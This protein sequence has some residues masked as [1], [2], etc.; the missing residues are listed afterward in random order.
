MIHYIVHTVIWVGHENY[1]I[2]SRGFS[3]LALVLDGGAQLYVDGRHLHFTTGDIVFF[4]KGGH[5]RVEPDNGYV[6]CN[7]INFQCDDEIPICVLNGC[8]DLINQFSKIHTLWHRK[9][10]NA[11]SE[12][13]C[14]G[15]LYH[16]FAEFYRRR[17]I[18]GIPLRKKK[19]ISPAL[20]Y[21]RDY[22]TDHEITINRLAELCGM[23]ER[24]FRR[25][26]H[27]VYGISP[28]RYLTSLRVNYAKGLLDGAHTVSQVALLCGFHDIY[29]FSS[30]FKDE[31]GMSPSEYIRT[32]ANESFL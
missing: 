13:D 14:M 30:F 16:L 11:Y 9:C 7:V 4:K 15:M 10:E 3:A 1:V 12:L 32:T 24:S 28:K 23:S 6:K 17:E 31:C 22:H 19:R 27:E 29:R 25:F 26:F 8:G 20:D 21:M 18:R 2:K 5:Y